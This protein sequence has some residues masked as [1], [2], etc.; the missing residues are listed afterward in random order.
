MKHWLRSSA[1][2]LGL[3]LAAAVHAEEPLPYVGGQAT[4]FIGDSDRDGDDGWGGRAF[5]GLPLSSV[6]NL[7]LGLFGYGYEGDFIGTDEGKGATLDFMVPL[8]DG[9]VRPF[10][11]MGGGW[12]QEDIG[13]QDDDT[14]LLNAG[15]GLLVGLTQDV[16]LRGDARYVGV[17]DE[18]L[19]PGVDG[20]NDW[21]L[22]LGLQVYFGR[23]EAPPPAACTDSDG[24]GVCDDA[25]LCPGTPAGTVVDA[26]GCPVI[27]KKQEAVSKKFED[28]HFAFDKS[29]L[30]AKNQALLDE[31]SATISSMATQYPDLKVEVS[32]HTDWIGTDGYNQGLSERRANTVKSYLVRKGVSAS[33][34]STY[35]Y[36]ESKPIAPNANPD[37]SDNPEGRALNRRAEVEAKSGQ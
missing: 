24:D 13:T 26:K 36:G 18:K 34:I 3:G 17:F 5:F 6:I 7:E 37:G 9:R 12:I 14:W 33:S 28:V 35:A 32:G 16:F 19:I 10:L 30:D 8:T 31:T 27:E 29:D 2:V 21:H 11:L 4:Y 23:E 1:V 25:D 22:N 15:A 20:L